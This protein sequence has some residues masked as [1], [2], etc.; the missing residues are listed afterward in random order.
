MASVYRYDFAHAAINDLSHPIYCSRMAINTSGFQHFPSSEFTRTT[1][2]QETGNCNL[3]RRDRWSLPTSAPY[4]FLIGTI[5]HCKVYNKARSF[6]TQK[7]IAPR[8]AQHLSSVS[9]R[10][11]R[12]LRQGVK[13]KKTAWYAAIPQQS[14]S[15]CNPPFSC[16]RFPN[17]MQ[18]H[19]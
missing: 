9:G 4:G 14:L 18:E 12:V 15:H 10:V 8:R 11:A 1:I 2:G 3:P 13:F 16:L 19:G 5:C 7:K 6:T 17:L